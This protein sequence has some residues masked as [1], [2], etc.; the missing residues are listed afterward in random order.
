MR[1][2]AHPV[3]AGEGSDDSARGP[4]TNDC[5]TQWPWLRSSTTPRTEL[6]CRRRRRW[7]TAPLRGQKPAR[8]GPG[9]HFSLGDE[10]V[11]EPVGQPQLQARVQRHYTE[12]SGNVCPIVQILDLP[13][14]QMVDTVFFRL[15]ELPVAEQVI[16][17]PMVSSSSCPSRA[18]LCEPQ[19]AEQLVAVPTVLSCALLQQR[20]V[21]QIC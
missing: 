6:S 19:M 15:L 16:E 8:A 2:A 13:V 5:R 17:V 7:S 10:N 9:T 3:P 21:E 12:D 1:L 4:N 14:P 20:N 18:D 11:P